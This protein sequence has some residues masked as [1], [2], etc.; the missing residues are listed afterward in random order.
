MALVFIKKIGSRS[1]WAYPHIFLRS[2]WRLCLLELAAGKSFAAAP[3]IVKYIV[4]SATDFL[5]HHSEW[6]E[7]T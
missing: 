3:K 7:L 4:A 2:P 6:S 1:S 5:C